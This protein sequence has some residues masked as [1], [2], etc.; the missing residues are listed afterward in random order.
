MR[1][2]QL[3]QHVDGDLAQVSATITW[4]ERDAPPEKLSL[5]TL[6]RFQEDLACHPHTFLLAT[7]IPAMLYGEKRLKIEGQVCPQLRNGL[8]TAREFLR[9]WYGDSGHGPIAIEPTQ[10]FVA[11][12]P[13]SS[14]RTAS[15]MS[16]GVDALTTL[17]LNRLDFPKDHPASIRDGILITGYGIRKNSGSRDRQKELQEDSAFLAELA[18]QEDLTIIPIQTNFSVLYSDIHRFSIEGSGAYLAAIAHAFPT[19]F[20]SAIIS[21]SYKVTY[22]PPWGTHPLLDPNYSSCATTIRHEWIQLTRQEKVAVL[23]EW[24]R[25]LQCL[26]VCNHNKEFYPKGALNCG[27]CDKCLRTMM[28]LLLYGALNRCPTFPGQEVTPEMIH[29]MKLLHDPTLLTELIEPLK[30]IHRDELAEA[31][32]QKLVQYQ[33]AQKLSSSNSLGERIKEWDH[34]YTRGLLAKSYG[35]IKSHLNPSEKP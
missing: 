32:E 34:R 2:D 11:P 13:L 33:N 26:H 21:A 18:T 8:N 17:R 1:I 19:R 14:P 9:H 16:G 25:G 10:G 29:N 4:E 5:Y 35:F 27:S 6:A 23:A 12:Y 28:E 24:D 15:Y 20:S 30:G 7:F 3:T 31:I 22:L